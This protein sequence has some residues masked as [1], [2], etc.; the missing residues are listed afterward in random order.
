MT[1]HSG[2]GI[3]LLMTNTNG[4]T[5]YEVSVR[6]GRRVLTFTRFAPNVETLI[7]SLTRVLSEDAKPFTILDWK[8]V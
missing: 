1:T 8:A 4:L 2:F 5:T 7:E 6:F 3:I